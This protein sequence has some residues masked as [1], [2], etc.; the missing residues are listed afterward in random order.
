MKSYLNNILEAIGNTPLVKL[1]KI[2]EGIEATVLAKLEMFNPCGSVKD[3]IGIHMIEAAERQGLI[4]PGYVIVEPTGGNT[5]IG[6]ALAAIAKGYKIIFT[7]PD[8]MSREKIDLLKAFGAEVIVTPTAVPPDHPANYIKVAERIVKDTPKAFMPNQ[9][10]NPANPD[11]HYKTT[12]QEIWEQTQGKVD[13]LVASMGTGGTI[14]GTGKYLKEKNPNI[15][16]I[17][18]DPEGS[19]IHHEFYGTTGEI[20]T[21]KVEGIGEDFMPSTLDLKV[22]DE[23]ITVNDRDSFLIT[24]RLAK[25]EGIFAGGSS[26]TALF[27][28]LQ[29][30]KNLKKGQILTV[31]LP[32]TGRNYMSKIYSDEWMREYGFLESIEQ[33]I[34]VMEILKYKSNRIKSIVSVKPEDTLETAIGL[35]RKYDIS[36]LPVIENDIQFGSVSELS[37]AKK[38]ASKKVGKIQRIGDIMDEILPTVNKMDKVL[39]PLS[40]L[41]DRNAV[42]VLDNSKIVDIITIIDVI[43]YLMRREANK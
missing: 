11:A 9:Y 22:I 1:N 27:A 2:T 33:R 40:L 34:P 43:N 4:K 35:L 20:H 18:A 26:G 17:G 37:I 31:I 41:K 21:Y 19:L 38:F 24:R 12:G 6:L 14:T 39:N 16:V 7:I 42:L 15:R 8:K 36:Q 23:I 32:D 28:A 25:E 3:R 29:I 13:V 5:G 10:F 30:A